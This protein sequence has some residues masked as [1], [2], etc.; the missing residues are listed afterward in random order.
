MR[1]RTTVVLVV[2]VLGVVAAGL[3]LVLSRGTQ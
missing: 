3:T 1:K 2:A